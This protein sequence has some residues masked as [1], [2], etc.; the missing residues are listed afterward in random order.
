MGKW[1]VQQMPKDPPATMPHVELECSRCGYRVRY[2]PGFDPYQPVPAGQ[3][4]CP[5]C[6]DLALVRHVEPSTGAPGAPGR[7]HYATVAECEGQNFSDVFPDAKPGDRIVIDGISRAEEAAAAEA[8]DEAFPTG[9][10]EHKNFLDSLGEPD[11][12]DH[13]EEDGRLTEKAFDA[14]YNNRW[15]RPPLPAIPQEG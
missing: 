8:Y 11:A 13:A 15:H 1:I 7:T 6:P 3:F 12:Q 14:E 2:E 5:F 9:A 4:A 10:Q